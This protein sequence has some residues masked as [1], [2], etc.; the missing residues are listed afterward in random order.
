MF[1]VVYQALLRG[2]AFKGRG[3]IEGLLRSALAPRAVDA[4]GGVRMVL[5]PLEWTQVELLA[6]APQEPVTAARVR[7]LVE[8]G[9]AVI[10]V[11]AHVGW[12]TLQAAK[13]AGPTGRVVAVD[14][15][16]YNCDRLLANARANGLDTILV[17]PA[18][19]GSAPGTVTLADQ[20]ATDKARLSLKE[21]GV[22]DTSLRFLATVHTVEGVFALA[23][24]ERVKL[25]KIDV[26]GYEAEV[27]RGAVPVLDRNDNVI[28]ESLPAHAESVL[29]EVFAILETAGFTMRQVD[30]AP[31]L[32]DGQMIENNIW[33]F[34]AR[35]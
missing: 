1:N 32:A 29:P 11:G 22:N 35:T 28:F 10:D 34:R 9:D 31:L 12:L 20:G 2:P 33:A 21:P 19:I 7:A 17:V 26:E 15:Q 13:A 18:A 24:L 16:P 5:D 4:P 3:R 23:E 14:P 25:L 30:G 6:G 27:L 8:A